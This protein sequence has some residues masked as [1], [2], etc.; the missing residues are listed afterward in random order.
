[1]AGITRKVGSKD[2]CFYAFVSRLFY[3]FARAFFQLSSVGRRKR[4]ERVSLSSSIST[5]RKR[6][7]RE[8]EKRIFRRSFSGRAK[9]ESIDFFLFRVHPCL[10]M[11]NRIRIRRDSNNEKLE[12]LV[13]LALKRLNVSYLTILSRLVWFERET[14]VCH[15]RG[16]R[17]L[18]FVLLNFE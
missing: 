7:R 6:R 1:M 8:N 15:E 2:S 11:T 17:Y 9:A 16:R 5:R 3:V 13:R 4:T 14:L 10:V 12:D 18:R